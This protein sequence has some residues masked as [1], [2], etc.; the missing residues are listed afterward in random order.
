V[1]ERLGTAPT[2]QAIKS[3]SPTRA[4]TAPSSAPKS[5]LK[6]GKAVDDAI[7][8]VK[9]LLVKKTPERVGRAVLFALR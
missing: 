3:E 9:H 4:N 6:K 1:S 7:A 5:I 2:P 8:K